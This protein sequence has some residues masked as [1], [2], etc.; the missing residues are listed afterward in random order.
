MQYNN[1][2]IVFDPILVNQNLTDSDELHEFTKMISIKYSPDHTIY[3][4]I[5]IFYLYYHAITDLIFQSPD[6]VLWFENNKKNFTSIQ[7]VNIVNKYNLKHF[8]KEIFYN[9]QNCRFTKIQ[10]FDK[11]LGRKLLHKQNISQN[12]YFLGY[13]KANSC[14]N[15]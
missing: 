14:M 15:F 10:I 12:L 1:R 8:F 6:K 9:F 4:T 5:T 11:A 2:S 7:I 13:S 3:L